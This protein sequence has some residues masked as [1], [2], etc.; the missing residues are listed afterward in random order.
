[1]N[2]M[3]TYD[4]EKSGLNYLVR[5]Y[6]R[7]SI[8]AIIFFLSIFFSLGGSVKLDISEVS[9]GSS[10]RG[11]DVAIQGSKKV[12]P[13]ITSEYWTGSKFNF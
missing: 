4:E 2:T 11:K 13:P 12:N 10:A 1:M 9:Y 8:I 5:K 3:D 7:V 6:G